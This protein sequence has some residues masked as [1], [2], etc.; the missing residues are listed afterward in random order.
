MS[1]P[2]GY[3][4]HKLQRMILLYLAENEPQTA[5]KTSIKIDKSYKP[6]NTAF[7][8]LEEKNLITETKIKNYRNRKYSEF[9]LTDEGIIMA[10]LEGAN[11]EK[12]SKQAQNL[13]PDNKALH[14]FLEIAPYIDRQII[15]MTYSSVRETGE[16]DF[17]DVMSLLF[18][19]APT[20]MDM[21][22]AKKLSKALKKYPEEYKILKE[23]KKFIIKQL[24]RI[25]PD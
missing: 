1:K 8:T 2:E 17:M 3:S 6:T 18:L 21:E 15:E 16:I 14:L 4:L 24:N 23:A 11:I 10:I 7:K 13:R 25:I 19:Q 5:N 9:W 20:E 12:L 22:N